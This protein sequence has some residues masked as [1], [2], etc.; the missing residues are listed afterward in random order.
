MTN[1]ERFIDI[2]RTEIHR[3]GA[4]KLLEWLTG[5]GSDFFTAPAST[6]YHNAWEG[7]LC[8]HSLNVYDCLTDYLDRPIVREKFGLLFPRES[9]A[10]VALLHDLC[11]VNIYKVGSRN[12]KD[13]FG[14]WKTVPYYEFN[15]QL[16][17]GHGEKSVY[18][19][20]GYMKLTTRPLPSA[21]TW[22]FRRRT[23]P[24]TSARPLRCSPSRWRSPSP[25]PRPP[26]LPNAAANSDPRKDPERPNALRRKRRL[27]TSRLFPL[28][29]PPRRK[30]RRA[31]FFF[32]LGGP[33]AFFLAFSLFALPAFFLFG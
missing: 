27:D 2:Y 30:V 32:L 15:D 9:V 26:S 24:A 6:R 17:Y 19:I 23:T 29:G 20:S 11:K 18:M 33:P 12:V 4:D 21:I 10:I 25:I 22:A 16:P 28:A 31:A 13:E 5:P 14:R 3:D 8:A 7:G 1:Q